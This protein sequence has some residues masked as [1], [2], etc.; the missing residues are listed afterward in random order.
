M[1]KGNGSSFDGQ[2]SYV[3]LPASDV[4]HEAGEEA[5]FSRWFNATTV[6]QCNDWIDNFGTLI[7]RGHNGDYTLAVYNGAVQTM[8]F[9]EGGAFLQLRL[10]LG[11]KKIP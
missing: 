11:G 3:E 10:F 6:P 4:L 5:T 2:G 7:G 1:R 9:A 8:F